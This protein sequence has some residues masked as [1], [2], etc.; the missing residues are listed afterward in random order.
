MRTPMTTRRTIA[1]FTLA[2]S[3]A[4]A[5]DDSVTGPSTVPV[6]SVTVT[7][8]APTVVAGQ[9]AT[10]TATVADA[11]GR[12]LTGRT[13]TW[14]SSAELVATVSPTGAVTAVSPGTTRIT[15]TSEG[16]HAS[17]DLTVLSRGTL[18]SEVT[19]DV[20]AFTLAIGETRQIVATPRDAT[21]APVAG[22]TITWSAAGG[23]VAAA[24][25]TTGLVTAL[26]QGV[27]TISAGV[28]GKLGQ[29]IVTVLGNETHD[30]VFDQWATDA[31]GI[32]R[33]AL[34]QLDLRTPN[35][36]PARMFALDGNREAAPSPDGTRVAYSCTEAFGPAICSSR[37]DGSD[38]RLLTP[39]RLADQ[40]AW[41]P[42]GEKIAFRGWAAGGP[43]GIF[44]PADI[45]VM[46]VDGSNV[47]RLTTGVKNVDSY[48]S[49]TW[50][51][52]QAD[53][54][55]RLAFAHATRAEDGV[56][57]AN[58]V[59]IRAD[60]DDAKQVTVAGDQT[61]A[62]P[63]WSPDGQTIAFIR[64]GGEA[65]GDLWLVNATGGGE[66]ALMT[67]A[68]EPSGAQRAPSWSPDG[69]RIA[70]ASDHE[71]ISNYIAWQIY[72]VRV[73]G[74]HL[75]RQTSGTAEKGNPAWIH[76]P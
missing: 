70:F 35:A 20:A 75:V 62:E 51:P 76:R 54:S 18:V 65:G 40:P 46:D 42:D 11:A 37:R 23:N 1:A 17:V 15:A 61:D 29:A 58:I 4:C 53:G 41:S 7:A 74:T 10:L 73:D 43:P 44:N 30:L 19:L 66:R 36:E 12:P 8:P 56:M 45:Y 68:I 3:A 57:R 47:A 26:E 69:R 34:H 50:S 64:T 55:Y 63:T 27:M 16:R 9:T 28:E 24:V 49:P 59:S 25:S 32:Q 21:G 71:I 33:P 67:A 14:T 5:G 6:A 13:I 60:G 31:G 22:V 38:F 48:E 72:T 39:G 52:R 2:A